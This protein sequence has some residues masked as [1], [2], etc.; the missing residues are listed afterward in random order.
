M[1]S[2]IGIVVGLLLLYM[3]FGRNKK[4]KRGGQTGQAKLSKAEHSQ[5][6][7]HAVHNGRN[8]RV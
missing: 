4:S 3:A 6:K 7:T 8:C 1:E 5:R 2:V